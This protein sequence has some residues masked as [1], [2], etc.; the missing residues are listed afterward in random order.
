METE[1]NRKEK[2]SIYL[3]R[4]GQKE[5]SHL[6]KLEN[7]QSP[8]RIDLPNIDSANLYIKKYSPK[9]TPPWTK[10]FTDNGLVPSSEFGFS[11]NVGAIL[12][13]RMLDSTFI[14][15]FGTG[16]HLLRLE[17]IERDFGLKVTLNSVDPDKLRSLDKASYDLNPL[18]SRTQSTLDV[19]IFNLHLDSEMEMLY[20]ITGVSIVNEFGSQVTGRDALTIAVE[21]NLEDIPRILKESIKRYKMNLPN[22]FSWVENIHRVRDLDEIEILDLELDV[23]LSSNKH[24]N[25]WLGEPEIIDWENQIGYSFDM[26]QKTPRFIVLSFKDFLEYLN[27]NIPTVELMKNTT[28]HVNNNEYQSI[29]KWS[30]YRCLYAEIKYGT[31][32]Y[33]L[34]N[35]IWYKA[36]S[37]FV[38]SVDRYLEESLHDYTFKF[39]VYNHDREEEYNTHVSKTE[40]N[41]CLM[42]KNNIKIGGSYDKLEHCDLIRNGSEFIHVKLYRSSSTLSHLFSQGFVAAEAFVKDNWYRG[43]LNPKLPKSIQLTD[44][45]IK[46]DARKYTIVYAIATQKV[47]PNELPF[48]SKITL[49][50]ALKTLLALDY[51]VSLAKIDIDP[52]LLK[53]KKYKSKT[54]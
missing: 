5:D 46:P 22:K 48:F 15:T 36:H 52:I 51:K 53:T 42:D 45:Q 37:D 24:E 2:L 38:N 19:D 50:N 44:P 18:N 39:P 32:Q 20:A 9:I 16:F 41:F 27:D 10:L 47:I 1:K 30:V 7:T 26:R 28:I 11:S 40:T 43:Q 17:A 8:I 54:R 35:G 49:K 23:Y 31:D 25:F 33:I 12:I 14:L 3:A 13:I 4:D 34:R 29:K 21:T 6:I